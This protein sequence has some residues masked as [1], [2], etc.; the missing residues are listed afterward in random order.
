MEMLPFPTCLLTTRKHISVSPIPI[1]AIINDA[2][3]NALFIDCLYI[4]FSIYRPI[5]KL[6]MG[7]FITICV[8]GLR[9]S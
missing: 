1:N 7:P 6:F 9:R 2:S 4:L 3:I 5:Y 8:I